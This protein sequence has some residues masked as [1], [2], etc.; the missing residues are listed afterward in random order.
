MEYSLKM[1]NLGTHEQKEDWFTQ[2][3]PNGRIPVI[4]NKGDDDFAVFESGAILMYLSQLNEANDLFPEASHERSVI[5]Q[6]LM[7][8]MGGVGPMLGQANVFHR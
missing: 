6:W 8:Q 4:K 7:F 3:N 1:V 2:M 5:T